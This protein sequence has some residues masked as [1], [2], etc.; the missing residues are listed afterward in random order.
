MFNKAGFFALR[1]KRII[2]ICDVQ[3]SGIT[4]ISQNPS[5]HALLPLIPETLSSATSLQFSTLL[6]AILGE[7]TIQNTNYHLILLE[8]NLIMFEAPIHAGMSLSHPQTRDRVST[9]CIVMEKPDNSTSETT[10]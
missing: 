4:C 5:Y 8:N 2:R 7:N 3:L 9:K 6:K 1:L 10:T